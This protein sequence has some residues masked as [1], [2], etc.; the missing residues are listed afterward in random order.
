MTDTSL[1]SMLQNIMSQ[2]GYRTSSDACDEDG[3][4]H[5]IVF[6]S[7]NN[8]GEIYTENGMVVYIKGEEKEG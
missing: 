7:E 8:S 3:Y 5:K 1:V 2:S 4:R 6:S